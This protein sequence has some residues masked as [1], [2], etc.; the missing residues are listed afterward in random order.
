QYWKKH[1]QLQKQEEK[2]IQ[3]RVSTMEK[4]LCSSD[5][6]QPSSVKRRTQQISSPRS[7]VP[8]ISKKRRI[9][10]SLSKATSFQPSL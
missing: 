9:N 5:T 7:S 8:P 3:K 2:R 4:P 1:V 10:R 6:P